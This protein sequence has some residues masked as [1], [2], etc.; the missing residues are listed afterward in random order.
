M[1]EHPLGGFDAVILG[2]F[3]DGDGTEVGVGEKNAAGGTS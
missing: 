2:F 3:E 1:L